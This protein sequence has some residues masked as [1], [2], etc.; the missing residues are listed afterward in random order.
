M[1]TYFNR[2]ELGKFLIFHGETALQI[3]VENNTPI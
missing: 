1:A 2:K 3:A